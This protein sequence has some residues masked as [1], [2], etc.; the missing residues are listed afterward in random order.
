M[1]VSSNENFIYFKV[2]IWFEGKPS[3][4]WKENEIRE[5]KMIFIGRNLNRESL[6]NNFNE[7]L[8]KA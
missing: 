2:F 1:T 5:N 6:E 8:M 4:S 3:V 7:C